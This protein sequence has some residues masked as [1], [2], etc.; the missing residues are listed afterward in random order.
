MSSRRD[1][2]LIVDEEEETIDLMSMLAGFAVSCVV[3][4]GFMFLIFGVHRTQGIQWWATLAA[5]ALA[6]VFSLLGSVFVC[7]HIFLC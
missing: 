3:C 2:S 6:S 7:F 4:V 5:L 1:G